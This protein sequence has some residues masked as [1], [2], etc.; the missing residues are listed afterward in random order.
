MTITGNDFPVRANAFCLSSEKRASSTQMSPA[1][2]LCFD[3]FSPL[4]GDNDVISQV[5]RLS[6][7][8]M[9]IAPRSLRMALG[10]SGRSAI[11]CM[12]VS[13]VGDRNLT[14]PERRSLFTSPWDLEAEILRLRHQL[15][16]LRRKSPKRLAFRNLDRLIFTSLYRLAPRVVNALVIVQ[17]KTVI[18]ALSGATQRQDG[19]VSLPDRIK[20]IA[21]QKLATS[22]MD[23]GF[24][25]EIRAKPGMPAWRRDEDGRTYALVI[26]DPNAQIRIKRITSCLAW[27]RSPVQPA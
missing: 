12:A 4:P 14:L 23:K 18:I 9:K 24:V 6:S 21:A 19:A 8:E 27:R 20:G 25:R 16:V 10:A 22:L 11:I 1:G 2:T 3:I 26:A 13:R 17:P 7:N 5:E 15:N